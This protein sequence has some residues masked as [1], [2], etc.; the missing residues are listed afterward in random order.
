MLPP[1]TA[2]AVVQGRLE[3][4]E[5]GLT[6]DVQVADDIEGGLVFQAGRPLVGAAVT[7]AA[8]GQGPDDVEGMAVAVALVLTNFDAV[9]QVQFDGNA[10]RSH[11]AS[12]A[13][14]LGRKAL[15]G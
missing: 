1:A 11:V 4:P 10:G 13:S 2:G 6:P 7:A 9:G 12:V 3:D 5:A 8:V 15:R 14:P